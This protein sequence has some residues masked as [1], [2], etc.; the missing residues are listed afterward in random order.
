MEAGGRLAIELGHTDQELLAPTLPRASEAQI[1]REVLEYSTGDRNELSVHGCV[2]LP[3]LITVG[4]S[5]QP[6]TPGFG[7]PIITSPK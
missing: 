4:D 5:H 7:N 1:G 6:S 3:T 2:I